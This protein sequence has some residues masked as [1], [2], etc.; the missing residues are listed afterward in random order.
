MAESASL[1]QQAML[2]RRSD[3]RYYTCSFQ[4]NLFGEWVIIRRWGT[5]HSRRGRTMATLCQSYEDGLEELAAIAKRRKQRGYQAI[6]EG[7][8]QDYS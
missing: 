1:P 7:R 3:G 6:E 2:W 5:I 4:Q 8:G